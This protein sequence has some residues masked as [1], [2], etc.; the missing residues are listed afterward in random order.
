VLH[1]LVENGNTVCVIEHS[2]DFIKTAD[3]VID[4]G[5]G[6]G[7]HGGSIIAEGTPEKI[8]KSKNSLTGKYL[9]EILTHSPQL[10]WKEILTEKRI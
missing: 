7:V 9:K 4:F 8:A 3:W 5:P 1:H 10:E 2:L 6:G